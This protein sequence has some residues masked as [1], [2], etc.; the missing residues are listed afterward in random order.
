MNACGSTIAQELRTYVQ[1]INEASTRE[2]VGL[3]YEDMVGYRS[4]LESPDASFQNLRD[5][6]RD[7][8]RELCYQYCIH[9]E[10]VGLASDMPLGVPDYVTTGTR[11]AT[12]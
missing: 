6:A 12:Q 8:V 9:C 7:Y 11:S 3:I 5:D 2:A 1:R 10:D 4:D